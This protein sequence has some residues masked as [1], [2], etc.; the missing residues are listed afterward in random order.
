[1]VRLRRIVSILTGTILLILIFIFQVGRGSASTAQY[2]IFNR[3]EEDSKRIYRMNTDGTGL[4]V[5]AEEAGH[6]VVPNLS[7]NG[8]WIAYTLSLRGKTQLYRIRPDGT[9]KRKIAEVQ[10]AIHYPLWSPDSQWV[11]FVT[12]ASYEDSVLGLYR[13]RY[14]GSQLLQLTD[15]LT[16]HTTYTYGLA[17]SPDG[18]WI[19]FNEAHNHHDTFPELFRV[20]RNGSDEQVISSEI[21]SEFPVW[22]PDG[23]WIIFSGYYNG[24]VE[25][26][27]YRIRPDGTDR[28]Q[29]TDSFRGGTLPQI[30]SDGEWVV[31]SAYDENTKMLDMYKMH[32]DGTNLQRLTYDETL[33]ELP[34][35]LPNS[36]DIVYQVIEDEQREFIRTDQDGNIE[37][38]AI[39]PAGDM[40]NVQW[41]P[42]IDM[43]FNPLKL[44]FSTLI[45][46]IL[47]GLKGIRHERASR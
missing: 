15:A 26:A 35:W 12:T 5:V 13:V 34:Q 1:M 41:S 20:R 27:V 17:C 2:I 24:D 38:R 46:I 10:A 39:F 23:E 43:P 36:H 19:A 25:W 45:F 42:T 40:N 11:A 33:E 8:Q 21:W 22:T 4:Q 30:S 14:D 29:L 28:E 3:A 6:V 7:P 47:F 9:G 44:G 18:E 37:E 31:F 32:P 16:Y